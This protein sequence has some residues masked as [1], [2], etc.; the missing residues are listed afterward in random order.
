MLADKAWLAVNDPVYLKCMMELRSSLSAGEFFHTK[1][2]KKWTRLC[3]IAEG[4]CLPQ[5]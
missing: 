5:I 3:H 1:L 4:L 2:A